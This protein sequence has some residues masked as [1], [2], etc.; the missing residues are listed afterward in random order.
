MEDLQ[1]SLVRAVCLLFAEVSLHGPGSRARAIFIDAFKLRG[2]A[3]RQ[4]DV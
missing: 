3:N 2:V 4:L 1:G